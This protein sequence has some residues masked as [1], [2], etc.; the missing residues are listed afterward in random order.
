MGESFEHIRL[1]KAIRS[2][3][4][5][6]VPDG[7]QILIKSDL[8]ESFE[9]PEKNERGYRSDIRYC[10]QCNLIIGE[11]KTTKDLETSHTQ[12][13]IESYLIECN[14]YNGSSTFILGVPM[15]DFSCAQN[16]ITTAQRRLGTKVSVVV[17]NEHGM[18]ASL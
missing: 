8:P 14:E 9:K 18:T 17:I 2:Y 10:Y 7:T 11:A 3:V 1:V 5:G 16:V 12:S 4:G 13:Q 15:A 6:L